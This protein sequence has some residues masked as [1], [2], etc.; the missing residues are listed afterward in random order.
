MAEFNLLR[1][2]GRLAEALATGDWQRCLD[3]N[4]EIAASVRQRGAGVYEVARTRFN[5]A[6]PLIRLGRLGEAGRLLAE[7][8]RVFEDH[9]DTAAHDRRHRRRLPGWPR[10]AG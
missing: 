2:A 3:L 8:Q 7:C 10:T 4:A 5:D 9:A 1:G 6:E